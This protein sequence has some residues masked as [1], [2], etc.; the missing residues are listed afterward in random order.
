VR[1]TARRPG[2]PGF[3]ERRDPIARDYLL[4][5]DLPRTTKSWSTRA[6]TGRWPITRQ[7]S[8]CGRYQ[9]AGWRQRIFRA[10]NECGQ[11]RIRSKGG[12]RGSQD[13]LPR[14][15]VSACKCAH[16]RARRPGGPYR[17]GA[18]G[19]QC[20]C[21]PIRRPAYLD[22]TSD[23]HRRQRVRARITAGMSSCLARRIAA[24][25]S[26]NK[27]PREASVMSVIPDMSISF[28]GTHWPKSLPHKRRPDFEKPASGGTRRPAPPRCRYEHFSGLTA[29]AVSI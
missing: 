10:L 1:T 15:P 24:R 19:G 12:N 17:R 9:A 16:S 2:E 29:F 5:L 7:P 23:Y 6:S 27:T 14:W 28:A 22:L 13:R 8:T 3:R 18:P 21:S 26:T 25:P 11:K 20:Q 4:S